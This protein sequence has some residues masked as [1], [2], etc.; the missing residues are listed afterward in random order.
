MQQRLQGSSPNTMARGPRT[1]PS[2]AHNKHFQECLI[3][4]NRTT[5]HYC[6][7]SALYTQARGKMVP[8]GNRESCGV[9]YA[10]THK[11]NHWLHMRRNTLGVWSYSK[12]PLGHQVLAYCNVMRCKWAVRK[13]AR[14]KNGG[15]LGDQIQATKS[16]ARQS[17]FTFCGP[18]LGPKT[19][20]VL[21][22]FLGNHC[23]R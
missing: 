8:Y 13:N 5:T 21:G 9:L 11:K 6:I 18:D 12:Q 7:L 4:A 20:L 14:T 16:E 23:T 15:R 10:L 2:K 1:S 19:A 22:P 17:G 3:L